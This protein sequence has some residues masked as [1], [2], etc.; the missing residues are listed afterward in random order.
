LSS[1]SSSTLFP[2]TTLFRSLA[3]S[4]IALAI[5]FFSFTTILMVTYAGEKQAEFLFGYKVSVIFRYIFIGMIIFGSVS[6]LTLIWG[7]LDISLT[8]T[9]VPNMIAVIL[10]SGKVIEITA[11]YFTNHKKSV[12]HHKRT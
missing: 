6:S 10:L 12:S 8:L 5:F 7:L 1:P 4:I 11:D 2:Y 9:V 3:G